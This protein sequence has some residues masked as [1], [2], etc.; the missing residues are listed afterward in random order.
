[1]AT[2]VFSFVFGAQWRMAGELT[3]VLIFGQAL[4]FIVSPLSSTLV[5]LQDVR[6]S[7][8]WQTLYFISMLWLYFNPGNSIQDFVLRYCL[9]DLVDY[10]LFFGLIYKRIQHYQKQL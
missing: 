5:A 8:I 10:S 7:A 2:P 4:K 3:A 1:L 6:Y 9:I